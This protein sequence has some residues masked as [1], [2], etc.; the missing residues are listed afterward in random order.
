[1]ARY[2][3]DCWPRPQDPQV[4][5]SWWYSRSWIFNVFP[6][7]ADAAGLGDHTFR[8]AEPILSN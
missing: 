1:M 8:T 7:D 6:D 4:N 2:S 3:T 5:R